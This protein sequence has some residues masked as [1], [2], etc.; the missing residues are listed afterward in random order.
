MPCAHI[1]KGADTSY[2]P[3]VSSANQRPLQ[4]K[5]AN[6]TSRDVNDDYED[7]DPP[8]PPPPSPSPFPASPAFSSLLAAP[9]AA[10]TASAPS[11]AASAP[12][13]RT[14]LSAPSPTSTAGPRANSTHAESTRVMMAKASTVKHMGEHAVYVQQPR[15]DEQPPQPR[16]QPPDAPSA[17]GSTIAASSDGPQRRPA[18]QQGDL[19]GERDCGPPMGG[20]LLSYRAGNAA[21]G[22][23]LP[24]SAAAIPM[25]SRTRGRQNPCHRQG[26]MSPAQACIAVR[27]REQQQN[28]TT[29]ARCPSAK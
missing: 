11:H 18:Q 20:A 28:G 12:K 5:I 2:A 24:Y 25:L 1:A 21:P 9:S 14:T 8:P 17:V 26:A 10:S 16:E 23:A 6:S 3:S 22:P 29:F 19:L 4:H 27:V 15:H 13:H 7:D